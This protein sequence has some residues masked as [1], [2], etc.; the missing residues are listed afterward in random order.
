MGWRINNTAIPE[1]VL[2]R[3]Q[4]FVNTIAAMAAAPSAMINRLDP[5]YLE[6]FRSN[7]GSEN[8][9]PSGT[10]MPLE[11]IYCE[12][13]ARTQNRVQVTDARKSP[14]WADSPTAKAGI[15]AYLGYPLLWPDG[16]VFG[17]LCIVDTKE[18]CWGADTDDL[19]LTFKEAIETYLALTFAHE[20]VKAAD[21]AKS[22][23]LA[24]VS[25][26][27][28]TP[29]TAI[30]GFSEVL[31]EGK[32]DL[33][34]RDAVATI[35]RNGEYLLEL[36]ND[37]LDMSKIEAGKM[38]VERIE[39]SPCEILC[40]V[41]S[42]MQ[43]RARSKGLGLDI[44]FATPVP[45]RIHSDPVRL[46][47]ILI[48]LVGNAVKF[49]ELGGVRLVVRLV[50]ADT[51]RPMLQFDVIDTGIGLSK[52]QIAKLFRPF[53]QVEDGASRQ[54][55][56]TGLGL[57]ISKRLAEKLGGS[58]TVDSVPGKGSTFSAS[59]AT[60]PIEGVAMIGC[61]AEAQLPCGPQD[62]AGP[63]DELNCQ[64]LL[65]EDGPDNQRLLNLFLTKAGAAV[66][67]AENGRTACELALAAL[68]EGKP[69]D[70]VLMDMQMPVMD[71]YEATGALRQAGY[72]GPIIALTANAMK[73]DRDRCIEVG[74]NDYAAKPIDRR[75]LIA[76][77]AHYA[78]EGARR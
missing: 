1:H 23:F 76:L 16:N 62:A 40:E 38:S 59:V 2:E 51:E 50:E 8:P 56:G 48:N 32:L 13:A 57:A 24:N 69:F 12:S 9:F 33:G 6:V 75:R 19:L 41:V 28:R 39:C 30:L 25:H 42:L 71:G 44:E 36:V 74:C 27:I 20:S 54:H 18:H 22:E 77:V 43:V 65:A 11:G 47:Q 37:I 61:P 67:V 21:Q 46:R 45:V 66:V 73:A 53:S 49:T 5:P 7:V 68:A 60:G 72:A 64:V 52:L 58:I 17:T 35:K 14:Q 70:V 31:M 63:Y 15:Y 26:E 29:M 34:Q 10:R 78:S 55:G 4:K 3:W